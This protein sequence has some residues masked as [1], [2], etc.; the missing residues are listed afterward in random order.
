MVIDVEKRAC[1]ASLASRPVAVIGRGCAAKRHRLSRIAKQV[2]QAGRWLS[3]VEYVPQSATGWAELR[4]K[5]GKR[6]GGNHR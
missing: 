4:S 1:E 5:S 3:S 6:V 2:W